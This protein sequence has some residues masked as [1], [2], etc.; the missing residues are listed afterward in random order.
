MKTRFLLATAFVGLAFSASS[1]GQ[2]PIPRTYQRFQPAGGPVLS[3]NL[4]FFRQDPGPLGIGQYLTFVQPQR[5]L[6]Q[7]IQQ[8]SGQLNLLQAEIHRIGEETIV[9]PTGVGGAFMNSRPYFM[10]QNAFFST[11]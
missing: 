7:A 6:R 2:Q 3:P 11:R 10:N 5:Q 1:F 9:A 4:Q 8:Q